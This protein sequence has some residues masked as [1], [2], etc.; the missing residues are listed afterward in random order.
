MVEVCALASGSN[1]NCY[2]VGN[3][4]EAVL[5]DAGITRKQVIKRL[6]EVRLDI[7]KIKAVFITH[8][9]ADHMKGLRVLCDLHGIDAFI[10]KTTFEK[11]RKDFHPQKIK[12]FEPGDSV[13]VGDITVHSFSKLHDA[14]DPCSFRVE[15]EGK[16]V[17]V[18]TDIG[19]VCDNV[20]SHLN[21]CD[22]A[23][24]ESNYDHELLEQGPYPYYLKQ[25]VSSSKGHL[26]NVQA[27]ELVKSLKDTPLKTIFLSHISADNNRVE[28]AMK[29]FEA[30]A[31]LYEIKPTSRYSPSEVYSLEV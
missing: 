9:H 24:L 25:R 19:E 17:G 22:L 20:Q 11:A 6:K 30:L 27:V 8:E 7:S 23:F 26:S 1:G 18:M 12:L 28:L 14:V 21:N 16:N 2:Y 31:H 5:I 10:T 13:S 15:L 3:E 29:E 4:K